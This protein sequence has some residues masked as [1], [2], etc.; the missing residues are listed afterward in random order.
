MGDYRNPGRSVAQSVFSVLG[1][2]YRAWFTYIKN[3]E[4]L[5]A[6]MGDTEALGQYPSCSFICQ[7]Q[8][9]SQH[10]TSNF[11]LIFLRRDFPRSIISVPT[12]ICIIDIELRLSSV[13]LGLVK[14]PEMEQYTFKAL[15]FL[16]IFT[17]WTLPN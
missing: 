4:V 6:I 2:V 17:N 3:L 13:T 1:D 16:A 5:D 14:S 11:A 8:L 12:S 7:W 9:L 10:T 15:L